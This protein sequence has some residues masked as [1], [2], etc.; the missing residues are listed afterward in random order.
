[1]GERGDGSPVAGWTRAFVDEVFPAEYATVMARRREVT[2]RA[3]ARERRAAQDPEDRSDGTPA[4]SV[5]LRLFGLAFSGGGIRSAT[6]NLG[7]IQSLAKRGLLPRFDYLSTVSGGGFIGGCL[8]ALL[9]DPATDTAWDERFPFFLRPGRPEP[10]ALRHLRSHSSYLATGT[11]G[12]FAL[13]AVLLRGM[14]VNIL[15]L[16]PLVVLAVAWTHWMYGPGLTGGARSSWP[17][18]AIRRRSCS[19]AGTRSTSSGATARCASG[20]P[21]CGG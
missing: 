4:P 19:R 16:T 7:V 5:R 2:R 10:A 14:L 15:T 13:A 9:N 21:S 3:A 1:M 8:S 17:G 12:Y 20:S 11:L 18:T 6:F